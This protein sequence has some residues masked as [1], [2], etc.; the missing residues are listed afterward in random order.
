MPGRKYEMQ[1]RNALLAV[2]MII[3]VSAGGLPGRTA[4][5]EDPGWCPKAVAVTKMK[6]GA[7]EFSRTYLG[8]AS[9]DPTVCLSTWKNGPALRCAV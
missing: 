9:D 3:L 1:Y 4:R 5:A 8:P 2:A 7:G 6:N